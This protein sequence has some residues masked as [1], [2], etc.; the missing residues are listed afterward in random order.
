MGQPLSIRSAQT[1]L[2]CVAGR[3]VEH[4]LRDFSPLQ[5]LHGAVLIGPRSNPGTDVQPSR[6]GQRRLSPLLGPAPGR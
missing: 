5:P 4:I 1:V 6:Y 2:N 3:Q